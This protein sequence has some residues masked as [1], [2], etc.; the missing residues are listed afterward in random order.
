MHRI[1]N[2]K[3]RALVVAG[4]L[5]VGLMVV[6]VISAQQGPPPPPPAGA[7]F[8]GISQNELARWNAGKAAFLQPVNPPGGLGPVFTENSCVQCHN[9]PAPGGSGPR[10]ATRIGRI[11]NGQFDPMIA[12][13]GPQIQ[14][15]GIG[16]FNGV[17]FVGEVVPPQATIVAKRRTIPLF[18]LGLVDAVPDSTFIWLAQEELTTSPQTAGH[19]AVVV[20]PLTGHNRIGK[21]GWKAQEPTLF[22]FAGD[23]SVNELGVTSPLFPNENCPQ[24]NC[25]LLAANP[26][27]THPNDTTNGV[28][29]Q[30]AD[31][32]TF[33]APPPRGHMGATETAGSTIFMQI[34]CYTCHT[35]VLLT[36][37]SPSPELNNVV[38][39]PFSDFLLHDMGTLGDGIVQGAAGPTQMRTAPLWGL[40]FEGSFL[41]DGRAPNVDQA[42]R[43]HAGQAT[44]S[45]N[46][47][48]GLN[49]T[50]RAQLLAYLNSL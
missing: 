25:A 16:V 21:F 11:V 35:P 37:P 42:I 13:G 8:S 17:N 31:F 24:G 39:A 14:D 15:K 38:F 46:M 28:L 4:S 32:M 9:G 41:H 45:R 20:D 26:A 30:L 29:Q 10:L 22:A 50:Q 47:Y 19:P 7:P 18:G 43:A 1:S 33:T 6:G 2:S 44:A 12:F 34:Q 49:A 48:V 27:R 23:A 40:R 3:K 36:G 5:A